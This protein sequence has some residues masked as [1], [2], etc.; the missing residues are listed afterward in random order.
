MS[1]D[2]GIMEKRIAELG[3][4]RIYSPDIVKWL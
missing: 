1:S 4:R 3:D 2:V